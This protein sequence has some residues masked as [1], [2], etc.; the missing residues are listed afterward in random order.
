MQSES[1]LMKTVLVTDDH[2][3]TNGALCKLLRSC[4][5]ETLSA[6]TGEAALAAIGRQR[7][8]L[9][10]LDFMMPGMDGMEVLRLIRMN[11]D[12]AFLPVIIYSSIADPEFQKHAVEKGANDYWLK[13][14]MDF[15]TLA[16]MVEKWTA[17]SPA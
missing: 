14:G 16:S 1:S 12:T 4:G 7:P 13:G 15:T 8:D 5:Y 10:I 9:V 11:P 2:A 6:L 17:S 3:P